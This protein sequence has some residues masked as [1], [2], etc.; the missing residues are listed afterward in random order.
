M[1]E[2]LRLLGMLLPTLAEGGGVLNQHP[3]R[4]LPVPPEEEL[5]AS[6]WIYGRFIVLY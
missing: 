1:V 3:R 5:S 4:H 2:D 6:L